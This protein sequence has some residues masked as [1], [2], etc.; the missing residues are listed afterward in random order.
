M[1]KLE[2]YNPYGPKDNEFKEY[3]KIRFLKRNIYGIEPEMVDEYSVALGKLYR[4]L[5][6]ALDLRVDDVVKRLEKTAK[7]REERELAIEASENREQ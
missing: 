1:K 5:L 4:W 6:L 2:G 7:L 3:Q